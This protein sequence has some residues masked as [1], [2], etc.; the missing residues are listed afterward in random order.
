VYTRLEERKK[1]CNEQ[2]TVYEACKNHL[3]SNSNL[4]TP[5][6][7]PDLPKATEKNQGSTAHL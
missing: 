7:S 2:M 4:P 5:Q 1:E 3:G 6:K